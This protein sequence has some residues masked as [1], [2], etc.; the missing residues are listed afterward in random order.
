MHRGTATKRPLGSVRWCRR[1]RRVLAL[2]ADQ[3]CIVRFAG[4]YMAVLGIA[5]EL[6][7]TRG[8]RAILDW[9]K[10]AATYGRYLDRRKYEAWIES[11]PNHPGGGG[12]LVLASTLD[13][14][15]ADV[16]TFLGLLVACLDRLGRSETARCVLVTDGV[17]AARFE[18]PQCARSLSVEVVRTAPTLQAML[19]VARRHWKGCG[20]LALLKPGYLPGAMTV[21]V[22]SDPNVLLYGDEDHIDGSGAC[23]NPYFK[24]NFSPDLLFAEDY[25]GCLL[26]PPG[27]DGVLPDDAEDY[28][29]LVLKLVDRATSVEHLDAVLAHRFE[30]SAKTGSGR[31]AEGVAPPASLGDGTSI[32]SLPEIP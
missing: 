30:G 9:A 13:V 2:A 18:V 26:V 11:V 24:P 32:S 17:A 31:T 15:P 7:R 1:L 19:G 8:L 4:G 25:V 6:A 20:H 28:H 12:P 16:D 27:L 10:T 3:R 5:V 29:S 23:S 21:P 22:D 14:E